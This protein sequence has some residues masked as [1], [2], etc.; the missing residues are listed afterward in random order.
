MKALHQKEIRKTFTS[1]KVA[2]KR[3]G[4][5]LQHTRIEMNWFGSIER[6][7]IKDGRNCLRNST[8]QNK[9]KIF[10]VAKTP[11]ILVLNSLFLVNKMCTVQ[12]FLNGKIS[13]HTRSGPTYST[14]RCPVPTSNWHI[15]FFRVSVA[16]SGH[17]LFRVFDSCD[18]TYSSWAARKFRLRVRLLASANSENLSSY[19]FSHQRQCLLGQM[20]SQ[21]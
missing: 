11:L 15:P 8:I 17:L 10:K 1:E 20:D 19:H 21:G 16:Q 3:E 7:I 5:Y 9:N 6:T 2:T 12:L 14:R 18:T 13:I 4:W